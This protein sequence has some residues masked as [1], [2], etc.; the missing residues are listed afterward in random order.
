MVVFFSVVIRAFLAT[1][2]VHCEAEK[3]NQFFVCIFLVLVS[4]W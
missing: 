1:V 3:R 2:Y 4:N